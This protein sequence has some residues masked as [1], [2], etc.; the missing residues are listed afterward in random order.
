MLS[1]GIHRRAHERDVDIEISGE[2]GFESNHVRC[3][4]AIPRDEENIIE[5]EAE[6]NDFVI[7]L[8]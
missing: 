2:T 5:C 3:D 7:K 8:H 1:D 4:L 6:A